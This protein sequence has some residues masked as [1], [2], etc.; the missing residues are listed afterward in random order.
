MKTEQTLDE[1]LRRIEGC[2]YKAYKEIKGE[3]RFPGFMLI[4]DHVQGDPFATP[5]K[6][7]VR[8]DREASSFSRTL[9][10]NNSRKVALCDYLTRIFY[11]NC[12]RYSQGSR[13]TGKS[14]LI[15]IDR[16]GQEIL[17][18]TAMVANDQWIEARFFMGLPAQGRRIAGKNA[19]IMFFEEL[20]KIVRASLFLKNLDAASLQTHIEIAED[21]DV[22]RDR[23]HQLDLIGFVADNALLPRAS[24]INPAPMTDDRVVA[25]QS[26]GTL[27]NKILLPNSGS[28]TGMGIPKGITLIAGGGYHGKSTLLDALELGIYNHIPND[29][30][31]RVVTVANTVKIRSA[32]GRNIVGTD[33]SP[34]INNLPFGRDTTSF[35]T[36]NASGSTSQAANISEALQA[37]AR[38]LLL[39]EDTSATNFMIRDHRMQQL[40]AKDKEPITPFIDKV[41]QLYD[42]KGVSTVLVMGGSGDYFSVAHQVIQMTSYVPTDVTQKAHHIAAAHATGR[43][44]E[45][46]NTFGKLKKRKPIADG[47]NPYRGKYRLKISAPRTDEILFGETL[48]N[49]RDVDQIVHISQTRGIGHAIYHAVRYMDGKRTLKEVVDRVIKDIDDNSLDILTPYVTGDITRFRHFE[50]TAAINRMR[51]LMVT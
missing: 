34:F 9:S 39:D 46:G 12:K 13:G 18:S 50:L 22:L 38:V 44:K 21:A 43:L 32:D 36:K 17:E 25:F 33:I 14:G 19:A 30:R 20:P 35:S 6:I 47:V 11:Q 2:G 29:G 28:I 48:I 45:G 4:I 5:S 41:R 8:V 1:H 7:R 16:P 51:T 24:G 37:G 10:E 3:Y 23:L 27:Q 15:V 40:V 31:E 42:E 49:M 26:P